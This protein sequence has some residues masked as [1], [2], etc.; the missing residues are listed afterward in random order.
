MCVTADTNIF[1]MIVIILI[2]RDCFALCFM[3]LVQKDLDRIKAEW[4]CHRIREC[5][6]SCCPSGH[7][8]ELY[9]LPQLLGTYDHV[10]ITTE[11]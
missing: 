5:R 9:E 1:C 7:P 10:L 2:F 6:Q 8:N 4:N 11:K 3:D